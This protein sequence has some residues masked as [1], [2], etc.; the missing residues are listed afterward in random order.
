MAYTERIRISKGGKLVAETWNNK[1]LTDIDIT[2]ELYDHLFNVCEIEDG[3]ILKDVLL[4][5][6]NWCEILSP[7]TTSSPTWLRELVDEGLNNPFKGDESNVKHLELSWAGEVRQYYKKDP[8]ELQEWVSFDGIGDPPKD[9]ENYKDWPVGKPVNYA[10]DFSPVDTLTELPIKLNKKITIYDETNR[11]GVYPPPVILEAEKTFTLA[12]ILRGIFWE[13]SFLGSPKDRN[14][15]SAE[16]MQ[17]MKDIDS[18]K[19][20]T[21]PWEEVKERLEKTLKEDKDL[22]GEEELD[23]LLKEKEDD[24]TTKS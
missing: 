15:K 14:E 22:M 9:D 5:V 1:Q 3:V 16:I 21:I 20:K 23:E 12:E 11:K 13:L 18:G 8:K 4:L 6:K 24:D 17:T 2:N 10:L 19:V 7:I